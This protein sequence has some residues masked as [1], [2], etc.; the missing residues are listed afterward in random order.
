MNEKNTHPTTQSEAV[1]HQRSCSALALALGWTVERKSLYD[2]EGVEGWCWTSPQG[3]EHDVIGGWN[4]PPPLPDGVEPNDQA[5]PLHG[6]GK[7][8]PEKQD[9]ES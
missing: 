6:R 2:E 3:V 7:T 4:E 9:A 8:Q 5:D 1:A